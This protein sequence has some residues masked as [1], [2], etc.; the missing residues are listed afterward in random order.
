MQRIVVQVTWTIHCTLR[1]VFRKVMKNFHVFRNYRKISKME[2]KTLSYIPIIGKKAMGLKKLVDFD[3][4][5]IIW[6]IAAEIYD[7]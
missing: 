6:Y 4:Q 3:R 1:H 2:L 7:Q 5:S